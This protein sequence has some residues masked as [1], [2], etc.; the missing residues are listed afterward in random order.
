MIVTHYIKRSKGAEKHPP[1]RQ[2]SLG[3]F[4]HEEEGPRITTA[5][6]PSSSNSALWRLRFESETLH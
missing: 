2:T 6:I 5:S 1:N 4:L 3:G